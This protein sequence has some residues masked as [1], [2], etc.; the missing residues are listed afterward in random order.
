M[1]IRMRQ[2][3]FGEFEL[4][5]FERFHNGRR[6][7]K[8]TIEMQPELIPEGSRADPSLILPEDMARDFIPALIQ[9]LRDANYVQ[10]DAVSTELKA[11][12]FHL[13]D[14]RKLAMDIK[15]KKT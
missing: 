13:E 1:I 14:M 3:L 10:S 7:Y 5:M 2:Q 8:I 15:Y 6:I 11:T 12:K 9:G 4:Y